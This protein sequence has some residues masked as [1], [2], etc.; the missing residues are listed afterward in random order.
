MIYEQLLQ[1]SSKNDWEAE[2]NEFG[3]AV[4]VSPLHIDWLDN[5][6][7]E[8][9]RDIERLRY[10]H[11]YEREMSSPTLPSSSQPPDNFQ[12]PES[13]PLPEVIPEPDPPL[14][15]IPEG[16]FSVEDVIGEIIIPPT[17]P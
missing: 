11:L 12:I 6:G 2:L 8:R 13:D 7:M 3:K 1:I 9:R 5:E 16:S 15:E 10:Y 17:N 4:P 14:E